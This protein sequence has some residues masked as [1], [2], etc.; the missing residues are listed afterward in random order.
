MVKVA[1]IQMHAKPNQG[2]NNMKKAVEMIRDAAKQGAELIV[3]PELWMS[4][5][6]LS[7]EEFNIFG[8]I[9]EGKT[10]SSFRQLAKEFGATLVV[11]FVEEESSHL[12]IAS[13]IIEKNGKVLSSY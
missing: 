4:G 9:L 11:P 7:R 13:V 1:A 10:V 8:E 3:L 6:Y 5:Y 12:Y 2:E